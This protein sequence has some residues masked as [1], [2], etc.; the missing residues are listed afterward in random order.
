MDLTAGV[1]FQE[2][3]KNIALLRIVWTVSEAH[4]E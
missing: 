2:R 3:V 4:P 1:L